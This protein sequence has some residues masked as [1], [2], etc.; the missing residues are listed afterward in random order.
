MG[1][2]KP[3]HNKATGAKAGKVVEEKQSQPQEQQAQ[4]PAAPQ[5]GVGKKK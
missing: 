1:R 4:K 5:Q 2:D 3:Q